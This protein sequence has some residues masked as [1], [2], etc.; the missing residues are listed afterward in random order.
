MVPVLITSYF[1]RLEMNGPKDFKETKVNLRT[2]A[3]PNLMVRLESVCRN[4]FS[5]LR[6]F[7][8]ISSLLP[9]GWDTETIR[10]WI[11]TRR[12]TLSVKPMTIVSILLILVMFDRSKTKIGCSRVHS[13]FEKM[14]SNLVNLV[15]ALLRSM[16][17]VCSCK[18]KNWL[19]EFNHP[20]MNMF[21]FVRCS[22]KWCS[23]HHLF[24]EKWN[25]DFQSAVCL[26]DWKFNVMLMQTKVFYNLPFFL[27]AKFFCFALFNGCK[28][29]KCTLFGLSL[30]DQSSKLKREFCG[31]IFYSTLFKTFSC[32]AT[33]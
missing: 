3:W 23:T 8:H 31:W 24:A 10:L 1:F 5:L 12:S 25:I 29:R 13:M 19:F 33:L 26:Q 9:L 11:S 28:T 14:M 17:D 30:S 22:T 20:S 7:P 32:N 4:P 16:F 27:G 2:Q 18:A 21:E 6:L 15:K